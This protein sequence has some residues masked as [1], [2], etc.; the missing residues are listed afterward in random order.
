L[1]NGGNTLNEVLPL[2]GNLNGTKLFKFNA[3]TQTYGPVATFV[4]GFG[5][6]PP[7]ATLEPGE[8]ALLDLPGGEPVELTFTGIRGCERKLPL[9]PVRGYQFLSDQLPEEG[10]FDSIV[11]LDP[12]PGTEVLAMTQG[13]TSTFDGSVWTPAPPIALVGEVWRLYWPNEDT[14]ELVCLPDIVVGNDPGQCSARVSLVEPTPTGGCSASGAPEVTGVRSDGADLDDA[15]PEGTTVITW[16]ARD[17]SGNS[18]SCTQQITVNRTIDSY[19]I[20]LG[21]G[22]NFIANQLDKGG[23]TL[24]EILPNVPTDTIFSKYNACQ[25]KYVDLATNQAPGAWDNPSVTL[26]PGE[27][28]F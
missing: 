26:Q 4:A 23:N 15:Y 22:M 11:G 18:E 27:G 10:D 21:P 20:E 13:A 2:T 3:G 16:T 7:S 17:S 8:A 12:V 1:D 25:Q 6:L 9:C 19:T 28:A 24:A 14:L 5:W